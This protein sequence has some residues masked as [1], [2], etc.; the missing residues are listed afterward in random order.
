[1]S[2]QELIIAVLG[3]ILFILFCFLLAGLAI[4]GD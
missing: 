4:A 1:M 3:I 2:D